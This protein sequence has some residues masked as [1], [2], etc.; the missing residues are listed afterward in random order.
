MKIPKKISPDRIKDAIV[1]IK[2]T[3]KIPFEI[4]VGLFFNSLDDSY[5]YTNRP[6]LNPELPVNTQGNIPLQIS[7]PLTGHSLFYNDKI[8][9]QIQ[10]NSIIFNCLNDYIGWNSY[11]IEIEKVLEQ[12]SKS[13]VIEK[14]VRIGMRYISEYPNID[15]QEC[16][17]FSFS[18]GMKNIKSDTYSFHSEFNW[19]DFRIILNLNNNLLVISSKET[20]TPNSI[21]PVSL[22]DIDVISENLAEENLQSLL[23]K[24]DKVHTKEKEVFFNLLNNNFL[25]SLNPQY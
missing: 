9:I 19:D 3:S 21:T 22:I 11:K 24:I 17:K 12:V 1:E 16:V 14:Y 5:N 25:S 4:V 7:F 2:Y 15:L 6:M 8:K 20:E 10:P 13:S 23:E 18:F